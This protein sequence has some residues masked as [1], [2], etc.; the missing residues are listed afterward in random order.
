MMRW[1][2]STSSAPGMGEQAASSHRVGRL[3]ARCVHMPT[4]QPLVCPLP[5]RSPPLEWDETLAQH[6]QEWTDTCVWAHSS[7]TMG[8]EKGWVSYGENLVSLAQW[9]A[10]LLPQRSFFCV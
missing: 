10:A 3:R 1:P 4:A 7:D 2:A 6:S 9:A 5:C 8:R